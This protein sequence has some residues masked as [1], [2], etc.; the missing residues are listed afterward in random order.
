METSG[1]FTGCSQ[2]AERQPGAAVG[3]TRPLE[4]GFRSVHVGQRSDDGSDPRRTGPGVRS[5]MFGRHVVF[6]YRLTTE[7][8]SSACCMVLETSTLSFI[9]SRERPLARDQGPFRLESCWNQEPRHCRLC[10][11][12]G[13]AITRVG[14]VMPPRQTGRVRGAGVAID[15]PAARIGQLFA[16]PMA[17]VCASCPAPR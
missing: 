8:M 7:S 16:S 1:T 3:R 12:T 5:F 13:M 17:C 10:E 9:R 2:H 6:Q 4:G 14:D 15:C 11:L